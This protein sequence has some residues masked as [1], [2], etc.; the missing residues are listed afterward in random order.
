MKGFIA[1]VLIF[2]TIISF[3]F[4]YNF[5]ITNTFHILSEQLSIIEKAISSEDFSRAEKLSSVFQKALASKAKTLYYLSDRVP[6]DNA[7]SE[8]AKMISFIRTSDKSEACAAAHGINAILEKTK[9]K[10][11]LSFP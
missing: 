3:L 11:V 7:I 4:I 1:A 5:Y 8:C 10:S 6:I 9:E 2:I